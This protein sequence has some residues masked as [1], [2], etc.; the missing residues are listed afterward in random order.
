MQTPRLWV[1]LTLIAV[2]ATGAAGQDAPSSSSVERPLPDGSALVRSMVDRQRSFEGALDE[3]TYDVRATEEELDGHGRVHDRHVR[4][5]QVFL[6]EGVPVR[7]LVEEDGRPLSADR[8]R[9]EA[10]RARKQARDARQ[11]AR[12]REAH[13]AV[14]LSRV[15][16]RFQFTAVGR[17]A[18]DGREAVVVQF[19]PVPGK[20]DIEHDNVYR[21]LAG[22]MW[23]DEQEHVVLRAEFSSTGP[24]RLGGGLIASVSG[25]R[26]DLAFVRVDDVWLPRRTEATV[27]GRVLLLK[28]IR[29]HTVEEYGGYRRFGVTTEEQ[30]ADGPE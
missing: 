19:R 29:V 13:E 4:L 9:K 17:E 6:V 30:V 23:I 14:V 7:Q 11:R 24:I 25:L 16:E 27:L 1:S 12:D 26:L 15:L 28:G 3:Y 22:R 2:L 5:N 20:R 10:E 21:V 8:A 18:V